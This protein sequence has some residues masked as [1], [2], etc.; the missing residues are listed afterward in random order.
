MIMIHD[1]VIIGAGPIGMACGIEASKAGLSFVVLEKGALV[2]SIYHYP[3]N[4][5]FFSTSEKIEIGGAPFVSHGPKPTRTEALEYYRRVA[6]QWDLPIHLYEPANRFEPLTLPDGKPGYRVHS[7]KATYNTRS[8][9]IATGFFDHPNRMNVPGEDLPKVRHY[10]TEP[11]P[12]IGQKVAVIGGANSAI[13]AALECYRKGA[14]VTL[15]HRG[16]D[17]SSRVKY[18]VKPDIDN[19]IKEGAIKAYFSSSVLEITPGHIVIR[20]GEGQKHPIENDFVLAMTGF[21]PDFGWLTAQGIQLGTDTAR[22]PVVNEKTYESNLP[23]VYLA[24]TVCG[25]LNTNRWFIE[26]A[27]EHARLVINDILIKAYA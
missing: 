1:A 27:I 12:Y 18:W 2:N 24:G 23:G 5:T 6:T 17:V 16:P 20:D 4:M 13:D 7:S 14:S 8:V 25:G 19:R 21:T 26:N 10:F 11:H 3:A 22:T 9:V 15:I